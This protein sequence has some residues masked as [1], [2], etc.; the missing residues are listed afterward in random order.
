MYKLSKI[1]LVFECCYV[2]TL[3]VGNIFYLGWG[4]N[5]LI[6]YKDKAFDDNESNLWLYC[7]VSYLFSLNRLLIFQTNTV[8]YDNIKKKSILI[9]CNFIFEMVPCIMGATIIFEIIRY[10]ELKELFQFALA[11]FILQVLFI[12]FNILLWVDTY[13]TYKDNEENRARLIGSNYENDY[14]IV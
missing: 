7:I 2:F 6:K 12:F 13:L 14:N 3:F 5:F 10:E 1:F 4:L 11:N 8:P 9:F